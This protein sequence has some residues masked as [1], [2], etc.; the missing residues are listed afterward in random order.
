MPKKQVILLLFI[1]S[2]FLVG[3]GN[4][5]LSGESENWKGRYSGFEENNERV[6]EFVIRPKDNKEVSVPVSYKIISERNDLELKGTKLIFVN[7][8]KRGCVSERLYL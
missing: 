4:K 2:L 8:F 1:L 5:S 3:C 7:F 6:R